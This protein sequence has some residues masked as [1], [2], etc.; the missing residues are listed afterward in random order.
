MSRVVRGQTLTL[1][2]R[3]FVEASIA[4]GASTPRILV[5]HILPNAISPVLYPLSYG[6]IIDKNE[7]NLAR[8]H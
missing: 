8:I 1:K 7:Q 5:R 4:M 3:Q 6:G 2:S